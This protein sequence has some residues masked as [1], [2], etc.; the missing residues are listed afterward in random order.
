MSKFAEWSK[1]PLWPLLAKCVV[2]LSLFC[3]VVFVILYPARKTEADA[4]AQAPMCAPATTNSSACRL[5]ADATFVRADCQN[6]AFPERDDF[7]EMQL[8]VFGMTLFIGVDRQR[9]H[10]LAP[11]T[12]FRVE[13]FQTTPTRVEFDGQFFERRGSPREAVHMLKVTLA[14]WTVLG[15]M[16]GTYLYV[17][18]RRLQPH[19]N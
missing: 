11:G 12:R 6:D 10:S 14:L 3:P 4:Y 18:K 7:C 16:A 9:V 19:K 2:A 8:D 5:I 15:L 17:R 1:I 13:L